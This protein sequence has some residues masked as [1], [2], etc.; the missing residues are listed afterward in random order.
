MRVWDLGLRAL[1]S[2]GA[3]PIQAACDLNPDNFNA[4]HPS[5]E[6]QALGVRVVKIGIIQRN[7][8]I[9]KKK[10]ETTT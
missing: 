2:R 4:H 10:M 1:R 9:L 7:I 3:T 5:H 6:L 8:G